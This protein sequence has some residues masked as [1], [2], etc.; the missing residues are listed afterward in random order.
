MRHK[1]KVHRQRT[2]I[3]P[4]RPK[5]NHLAQHN[6]RARTLHPKSTQRTSTRHLKDRRSRQHPHPAH[7]VVR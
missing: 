1:I 4:H 3:H 5:P 2:L 7:Q 6:A